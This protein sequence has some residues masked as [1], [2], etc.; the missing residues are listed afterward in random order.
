M[1]ITETQ[2]KAETISLLKQIGYEYANMELS[3]IFKWLLEERKLFVSVTTAIRQRR[4]LWKYTVEDYS[5]ERDRNHG[6][7]FYT[8]YGS[9]VIEPDHFSSYDEALEA[10]IQIAVGIATGRVK[11]GSC[12]IEVE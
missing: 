8:G 9:S 12:G 11:Y 5:E 3:F 7:M 10:G 4:I 6:G 1:R 2:A